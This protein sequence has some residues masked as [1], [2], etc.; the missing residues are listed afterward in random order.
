[1]WDIDE[2]THLHLIDFFLMFF[3]SAFYF[4]LGFHAF[5]HPEEAEYE[6]DETDEGCE[7]DE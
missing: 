3:V 4:E 1:M 7:E 6:S 2:E 5:T